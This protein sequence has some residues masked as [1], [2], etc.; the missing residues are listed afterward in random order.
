MARHGLGS[1]R[2]RCRLRGALAVWLPAR[3]GPSAAQGGAASRAAASA[4]RRRSAEAGA[5][6]L[7]VLFLGHDSTH[8][9]S[10]TLMPLLAAPLARHG[11]QLT[12]V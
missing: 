6:P 11:I 3:C 8:H 2:L 9:P 12:H 7:R 5:R 4:G 1:R 10:R